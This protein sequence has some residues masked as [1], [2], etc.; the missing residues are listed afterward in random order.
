MR[1]AMSKA[2]TDGEP[3]DAGTAPPVDMALVEWARRGDHAAYA[4]LV[5]RYTPLLMRVTLRLLR[6]TAQA[7][8]ACQEAF[9]RAYTHLDEYNPT[10]RFSTWLGAIATH[11]CL[12]LL[13]RRDWDRTG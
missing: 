6:D 8:D 9:L 13:A 7:E 1:G 11:H 2:K 4:T 5:D 12:R 10:Y 3:G